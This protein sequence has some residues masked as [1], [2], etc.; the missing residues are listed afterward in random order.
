MKIKIIL[1]LIGLAISSVSFAGIGNE[2]NSWES[3]TLQLQNQIDLH[4]PMSKNNIL[5]SHNT[6]NSSE[7]ANDGYLRYIDPQQKHTIK[8]QLQLG[9]RFIELDLHWKFNW[10]NWRYHLLLCHGGFCSGNDRFFREGLQEIKE[11]LQSPESNDQVIILYIEDHATDKNSK[12]YEELMGYIGSYV[13]KSNG[14]QA[15][16]STLTKAQVLNAG[17]QVVVWKDGGCSSNSNMKNTAF[18]SLGSI[19]RVWEDRTV[20]GAIFDNAGDGLIDA[21]DVKEFFKLGR[22]IVN[23]DDFTYD[24]RQTA[25][26]WS[27]NTNEPN[28]SNNEDCA[29]M[30]NT[31]R[32][33]DVSCNDNRTLPYACHQDGTENWNITISNTGNYSGGQA[34]CQ[35]LGNDWHFKTPTNSKYNHAIRNAANDAGYDQ[36]WLAISDAETEGKWTDPSNTF[37]ITSTTLID[38]RAGLCMNVWGGNASNGADIKLHSCSGAAN[39]RFTYH[40]DTGMFRSKLNENYCIDVSGG[41]F[42]NGGNIQLWSCST[43]NNN[44]KFDIIG[45]TIRPRINHNLAI[46]AYGK[47]QGDNVGLWT[48]H[49]GSN[50]SWIGVTQ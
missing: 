35:N 39:E 38:K 48:A 30:L 34:A 2:T 10:S 29:V 36:V 41:N 45:D 4:S 15:I 28:N 23:L 24:N 33:N 3:K 42:S 21:T 11:W 7:Y 50:Q 14:C 6:Y 44:Q 19:D 18:S 49:G 13:Y 43:T 22:N 47:N 12:M 40:A 9:A 20:I 1:T 26:I 8:E 31:G 5:G 46:D 32:W 17:A 27:W 37:P 25:A 16:P